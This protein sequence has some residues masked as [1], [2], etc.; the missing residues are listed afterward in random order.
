MDISLQIQGQTYR[1]DTDNSIDLSIPLNFNGAQPNAYGVGKAT[2][3]PCEA[4]SL[5]GDTRQGGSCNFERYTFIPHC[6]GTHTECIGHITNERIS[7]LESLKDIFILATLITVEP[8]NA[9]DTADTYTPEKDQADRLITLAALKKALGPNAEKPPEGEAQNMEA[10]IIRTQPNDDGKKT[11]DYMKEPPPFFSLEAISYIVKK[12]VEH[13]LV[14]LPS[15]DRMF[16]EGKLSAH[17]IFWNMPPQSYEIN[18]ESGIH[19]TVTEMIYV[20]N[21]VKDGVYL[22]NL[23]IAPFAADAAPSR[24]L[25]FENVT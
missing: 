2:S 25:I 18:K 16:D 15:I 22:L 4:G 13:L 17:R 8:E 11:R 23:Q 14:D 3:K 12:G 21:E 10:L 1:I 6:N 19:R 7:I 20:P 5:V 24:P 9:V